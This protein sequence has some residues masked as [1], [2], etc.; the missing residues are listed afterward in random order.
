MTVGTPAYMSPEQAA[1]ERDVD[2]RSD[3]YSLACVTYEMLAGQPPFSGAT[4]EALVRQHLA[5]APTSVATIRPTVTPMVA[6]AIARALAKTP[7]DRFDSATQF[8]DA[9]EQRPVVAAP[10]SPRPFARRPAMLIGTG[11]LA[12][13]LIATAM[14]RSR[15]PA[16]AADGPSSTATPDASR[17]IAVLPFENIDGDTSTSP[18]AL[19]VHAEVVTQLS[20]LGALRVTSRGSTLEY[21][22]S[23]KRPRDIA[24]ELGV[25]TLLTGS[26]QRSGNK[27]R[28]T[29][30]LSDPRRGHQL[31]AESY[32][33][34]LTAENLFDVQADIARQVA[35]AL[36]VRMTTEQQTALSRAPTASLAAL[37]RYHRA[38]IASGVGPA[39]DDAIAARLLEEAVK[40][41]SG[42]VEAWSLLARVR[43][44]MLRAGEANDTLDAWAAVERTA[45]LAPGSFE[46]H[47]ARGFYRYYA[48]ADYQGALQ[49]FRQADRLSPGSPDVS[50]AIGYVLRRLG[51]WN[52]AVEH[53]QRARDLGPRDVRVLAALGNTY[54]IMRRWDDA[55]RE[56]DR[57]L[58]IVPSGQ[59]VI[60][61]KF[62]VL[63]AGRGDTASARAFAVASAPVLDPEWVAYTDAMLAIAG[64]RYDVA[65]SAFATYGALSD[66]HFSI[67]FPVSPTLG[68]ALSHRFAGDNVMARRYA[69][70][71]L[72]L[73]QREL[74][75]RRRRGP[76]DPFGT[77]A[78]VELQMAAASAIKGE[79]ATAIAMAERAAARWPVARDAVDGGVLQELLAG[80]YVLAGR[81]REAVETLAA[82][83]AVPA[84]VSG[85][86]LRLD[87]LWDPLRNRPEFQALVADSRSTPK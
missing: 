50:L 84:N 76:A 43:S 39:S 53:L 20:K 1:G 36:Q 56:F 71:T 66:N 55:L 57:A 3:I 32:D 30:D 25:T 52:E 35:A 22:G 78:I 27:V 21:R 87:P 63:L 82:I 24:A 65:A 79:A 54:Q 15:I 17:T 5:V 74:A 44:Y 67:D 23:A 86:E 62:D 28:L 16:A 40:L 69:D 10:R 2:A 6:D 58:V 61:H 46:P 73:G 18:L 83:S 11:L 51:R 13:A 47:V 64:R 38:L 26:V 48:H 80:V 85:V 75:R 4:I 70:S 31:W 29:V 72:A 19:G 77:Q 68:I 14:W 7:A 34:E 37:D 9:L 8:A 41:D 60:L 49:L 33:R 45:T 81:P 42:F 59:N 12:I